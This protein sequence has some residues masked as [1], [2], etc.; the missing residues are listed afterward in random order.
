MP[1][2]KNVELVDICDEAD[3]HV[4]EDD[5]YL[6]PAENRLL[7][8][9]S[10]QGEGWGSPLS[11]QMVLNNLFYLTVK[12]YLY[13]VFSSWKMTLY[14]DIVNEI[15]MPSLFILISVRRIL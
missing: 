7:K 1:W 6:M 9:V 10:L 11:T 5:D 12:V 14:K 2:L 4:E 13:Y 8:P 15:L 3:L